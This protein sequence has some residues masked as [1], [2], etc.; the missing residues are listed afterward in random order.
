MSFKGDKTMISDGD[1]PMEWVTYATTKPGVY[2]TV[3]H[4]SQ[5]AKALLF[6]W[7]LERGDKL[8][9]AKEA[10]VDCLSGKV[11]ADVARAA[12]LEAC[13]EAG[14]FVRA[15]ERPGRMPFRKGRKAK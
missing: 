3:T 8:L 11:S 10:C 4:V 2:R 1:V 5:V 9:K 13:D 15:D 12:F 6:E 14:L 7:P